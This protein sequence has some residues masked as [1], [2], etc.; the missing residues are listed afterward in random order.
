MMKKVSLIVPVYNAAPYL[1]KCMDSLRMQTLT[2]MEVVFV[3]DH[4]QDDSIAIAQEYIRSNHLED[5]WHIVATEKNGGPGIARNEGLKYAKGEYIAFA[6]ADDWMEKEMYEKLY[7]LSC[8]RHADIAIC[9][10]CRHESQ[11]I[12]YIIHP[13]YR[14]SHQYLAHYVGYLWTYMFRRDFIERHG[15]QFPSASSAEDSYF[16]A[17]AIM[18]TNNVVQCPESLY[19]YIVYP[20]S[21]SHQ[22]NLQRHQQKRRVF[23]DLIRFARKRGML[24]SYRW[25]LYW[26]YVKKAIITSVSDYIASIT[27]K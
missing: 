6:D 18:M 1:T 14:S 10:A 3:D 19:H 13:I 22:K 17:T 24:S 15:L 25:V 4:G 11:G 2:E 23:G 5:S 7:K 20:T 21:I 12:T 9:N 27:A 16:I 26:V 8:E